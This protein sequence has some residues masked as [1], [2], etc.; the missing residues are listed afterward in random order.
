MI[1]LTVARSLNVRFNARP[2]IKGH[3]AQKRHAALPQ[4]GF[5]FYSKFCGPRKSHLIILISMLPISN[6]SA[7]FSFPIR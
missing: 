7:S 4:Q 5:S 3:A 2:S 6:K 1:R